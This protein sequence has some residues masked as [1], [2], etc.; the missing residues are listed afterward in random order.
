MASSTDGVHYYSSRI[1][2]QGLHAWQYGYIECRAKVPPGGV[3]YKGYWPAFWTLGTDIN[4]NGWPKCG[5]WH[6]VMQ[7]KF[8][9]DTQGAL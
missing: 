9:E 5:D 8:I 3:A 1:K 6:I 2:T 7:C 4:S